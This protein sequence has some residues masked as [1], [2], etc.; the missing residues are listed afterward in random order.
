MSMKSNLYNLWGLEDNEDKGW[1]EGQMVKYF[2][3]RNSIDRNGEILSSGIGIVI[4]GSDLLVSIPVLT[5]EGEVKYFLHHN[6]LPIE[7]TDEQ[8]ST[9]RSSETQRSD[10]GARSF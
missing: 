2:V 10:S 8:A 4:D 9:E 5:E 7:K 3:R 6:L 1:K